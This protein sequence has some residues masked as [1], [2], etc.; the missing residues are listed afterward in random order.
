MHI[1]LRVVNW[2]IGTHR[3]VKALCFALL[4]EEGI[5]MC[6][7]D[8]EVKLKVAPRKLHTPRDGSPFTEGD[9]LIIRSA[10]GQRIATDN[11]LPQH[12]P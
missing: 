6:L 8:K 1:Q 5:L 3:F 4:V 11:I 7:V 10:I 12:I 2:W 9:R